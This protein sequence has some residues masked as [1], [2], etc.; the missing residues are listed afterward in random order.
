M[1]ALALL[2]A[3]GVKIIARKPMAAKALDE[4]LVK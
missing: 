3:Y 2:N 4:S 1:T